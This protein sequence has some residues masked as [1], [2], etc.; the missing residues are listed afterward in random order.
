MASYLNYKIKEF[1]IES[2]DG[3]QI[4]DMTSSVA[5]IK[6]NEDLWSPSTS[7]SLVIVNTQGWLTKLPIMGGE[8]IYLIIEQESTG[9]RLEF[10]D[11]KNTHYIYKIFASSTEDTREVFSIELAPLE[12]FT[13]ET[14]RVFK[15]YPESEGKV[16]PIS[17]SVEKILKDVLKTT[18]QLT[19]EQTSNSYSFYG[20]SKKPFT[21][22]SWLMK[23]S[24]PYLKNSSK[25]SKQ[26]G[27]AGFLFYENKRGYH[28][29]SLDSLLSGLNPKTP[30]N[31]SYETYVV[32][33]AKEYATAS[34]NYRVLDT[35]SFEKNID[36]FKN[37]LIGMYSSLNYFFDIN[38]RTPSVIT[39]KLSDSYPIMNHTSGSNQPPKLLNNLEDRPSRMMAKIVDNYS[40]EGVTPSK[41][42]RDYKEYY[43]SQSISRYNLAFS[44]VLNI[45]VPLN[46]K[47]TVGD[48]IYL[49]IGTI[50]SKDV[51]DK[52]RLKSGLYLIQSLAHQFEGNQ[53]YTGLK[54]V[55]DSYGEPR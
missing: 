12:L 46:M 40:M 34:L 47:L 23:K 28:F 18:K 11:T 20:N 42:I 13:N 19:V 51:K 43:Q 49:N 45:T 3:T 6:Y 31:I 52:D 55:R 25:S 32:S 9:E 44:Q 37:M 27:S 4:I 2:L 38:T 29:R 8:R 54:L 16:E 33:R 35:P 39:Y 17:S 53:G 48:V 30:N 41:N 15:R 36:V 21:V 10:T 5:S 14:T 26:A 7:I 24:I 50:E 22:L 1:K